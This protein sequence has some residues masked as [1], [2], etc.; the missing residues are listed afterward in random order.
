MTRVV[1]NAV[2]RLLEA[3]I[4]CLLLLCATL[5][6][7]LQEWVGDSTI[8]ASSWVAAREEAHAALLH[9]R[10]PPGAASWDAVGMNGANVRIGVVYLA[11]L[12]HRLS[13]LRVTHVY[14]LIDSIALFCSF[15]LLFAFLRR[16]APASH[17]TIGVLFVAALMPLTY[18]LHRY[19]PW[20][21][22]SLCLWIALVM[23]LERRKLVPFT[24]LLAVAVVVKYD[25]AVLPG[26]YFL[27][28]ADADSWRRVTLR[29]AGLL[30]LSFGIYVALSHALPGGSEP[31]AFYAQMRHNL[32]VIREMHLRYPPLLMFGLV[33]AVALY[34]L[35][36]ADRFARACAAFAAIVAVPLFAATNFVEVRAETMLLILLL[37]AAMAGL[38]RLLE[39]PSAASARIRGVPAEPL[40][41]DP[42]VPA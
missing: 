30:L 19:H 31:R 26:L 10:L 33:T 35:R 23:L 25:V 15:L 5:T 21:R 11:E 3:R 29:T 14:H 17:A 42:V 34:G 40:L 22:V 1:S 9:N 28:E 36:G 24:L 6:L 18:Y 4:V 13:G 39:T 37:P 27:L 8:Y 12:G 16:R 32:T 41:E 7:T 20:D 38:A 2:A